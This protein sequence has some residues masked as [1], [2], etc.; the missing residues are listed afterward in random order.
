MLFPAMFAQSSL[1]SISSGLVPGQDCAL[2]VFCQRFK[3]RADG[4]AD[5]LAY[6]D[7]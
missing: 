3:R 6:L 7:V 1:I 5:A 2:R 4:A